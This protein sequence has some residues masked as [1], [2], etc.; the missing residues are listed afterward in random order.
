MRRCS[1]YLVW[2]S[3]P[4]RGMMRRRLV[5]HNST[6]CHHLRHSLP[7]VGRAGHAHTELARLQAFIA[8]KDKNELS[9]IDN[10]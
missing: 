5:I 4:L 10:Y 2:W 7:G 3:T 1:M 6:E 9:S 8:M